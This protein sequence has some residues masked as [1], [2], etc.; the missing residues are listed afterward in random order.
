MQ[1]TS[2]GGLAPCEAFCEGKLALLPETTAWFPK[3]NHDVGQV[4]QLRRV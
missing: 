1:L 3:E 2:G 4:S